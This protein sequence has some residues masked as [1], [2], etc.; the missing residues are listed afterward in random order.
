MWTLE[1]GGASPR[2]PIRRSLREGADESELNRA[3]GWAFW[4]ELMPR[5]S[6]GVVEALPRH[7]LPPCVVLLEEPGFCAW[8]HIG[9]E[10]L[11][12]SGASFGGSPPCILEGG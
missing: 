9:T 3:P 7:L 11:A 4:V 12:V 8:T 10:Y 5:V 2:R 1:L 6:E